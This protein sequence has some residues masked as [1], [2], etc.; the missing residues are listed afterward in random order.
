M[1]LGY[2]AEDTTWPPDRFNATSPLAGRGGPQNNRPE[3][4]PVIMCFFYTIGMHL[5]HS[6]AAML[7]VWPDSQRMAHQLPWEDKRTL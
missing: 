6:L 3:D 5:D 7:A 1:V 4:L 2:P